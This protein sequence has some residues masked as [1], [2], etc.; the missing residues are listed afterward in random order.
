MS[1]HPAPVPI[2][3]LIDLSSYP[4]HDPGSVAYASLVQRCRA[5][6]AADGMFNLD[7]LVTAHAIGIALRSLRPLIDGHS[8]VHRR[9]H[10]IYFAAA[11]AG[12]DPTHPAL[13]LMET[14][15][16]TVCADQVAQSPVV[17]IYEH[18][19]LRQLL[20]DVI[21]AEHLYLMDDPL[22]RVN[23]MSYRHGE[24]L[25]WHFDR[26]E[27][28]V[29]L[30]LQAPMSGGEFQYR[31]DLRA[32]GDPNHDGVARLLAGKDPEVIT[33]VIMPGTLNVFRGID[34]AHRV[35]PVE[36][37]RDRV[38]AVYSYYDRPGVTFTD[39]ERMGFYGR[40]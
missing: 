20:A 28:T 32:A 8:F 15:N 7:R 19:G 5:D 4:L 1:D 26:A 24:A 37:D 6:L 22:A 29:T 11:V 40:R 34:T 35:T 12:I 3:A 2:E 21:G 16:R 13:A 9:R 36:G 14:T 39:D 10:N 33:R 18:G 30:L 17:S 38:V 23:V 25:N 31:R 27:F